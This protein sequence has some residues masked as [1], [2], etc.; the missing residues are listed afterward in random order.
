MKLC[1]TAVCRREVALLCTRVIWSLGWHEFSSGLW[2]IRAI[3]IFLTRLAQ[4]RMTLTCCQDHTCLFPTASNAIVDLRCFF[5]IPWLTKHSYH[6]AFLQHIKLVLMLINMQLFGGQWFEI[7]TLHAK[8][9][10]TM[11]PVT[12][13]KVIKLSG[14]SGGSRVG[15]VGSL[16][17]PPSVFKYP[18]KM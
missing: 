11:S 17:L 1:W 9:K 6:L 8:Y 5:I 3:T 12:I 18:M 4:F 2:C 7:N 15:S 16:E 14:I 10:N 13:R